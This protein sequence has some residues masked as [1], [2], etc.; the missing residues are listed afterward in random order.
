MEHKKEDRSTWV[1]GGTTMIGLG[2]GMIYLT[3][4]IFT[5]IASILIGIGFG[6]VIVPFVPR[7]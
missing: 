4:S 7:N 1:I 5:F 3:T 6:L 2:V